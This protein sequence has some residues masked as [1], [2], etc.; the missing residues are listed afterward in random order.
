MNGAVNTYR[1]NLVECSH[2]VNIAVVDNNNKLLK[3]YSNPDE[4]IYV[5]FS[6]K[7]IQAIQ[8][9]ESGACEKYSINNKEIGLIWSSHSSE[10]YH[11]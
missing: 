3:Y 9:L 2:N 5:R 4:I 1:E 7:P 8:V 6:V 10:D 11:V